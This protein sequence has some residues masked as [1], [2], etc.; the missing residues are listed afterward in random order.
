M[1]IINRIN[2]MRR[3]SRIILRS[4]KRIG[5][6]PTMGALHPG[7][8]HLIQRARIENDLVVVSIFVNPFQFGPK[9]DFKRYPRNMDK[10]AEL[11]RS[12]GVDVIFAPSALE[13]YPQNYKTFV[14]VNDLSGVLC[15]RSRPGHFRGVATVV[16]KLLNIVY[17]H[18]VYLGQKDAQQVAVITRLVRD[19]NF[20]VKI[21]IVPTVRYDDGLA[22]SSRNQYLS[23]TE[24][25]DALVI[26]EALNLARSLVNAGEKDAGKIQGIMRKLILQKKNAVIDYI[27]VVDSYELLPLK[28]VIDGT[29]IALAVKIGNTRL[30]DNI[31]I[32]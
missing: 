27:S 5:F 13:M 28:R 23:D 17:P 1:R 6:V 29:L 8:L 25:R 11:C 31:V 7:H 18:A 26:P 15:G 20:S 12:Q 21:R 30:I 32:K 16:A 2:A 24:R 14:E 22:L 19:L 3:F 10:D 9:E 4:G